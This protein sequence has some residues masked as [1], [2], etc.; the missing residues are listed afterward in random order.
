MFCKLNNLKF[1]KLIPVQVRAVLQ[2]KFKVMTKFTNEVDFDKKLKEIGDDY[3]LLKDFLNANCFCT[4][5][6]K[7]HTAYSALA[8]LRGY[9][10]TG[11]KSC[12]EI[13]EL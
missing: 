6:E 8:R 1:N 3:E 9:A 2:N 10:A 7:K 5:Y 4:S 13:S 12:H 11:L